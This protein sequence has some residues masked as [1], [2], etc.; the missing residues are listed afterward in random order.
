MVDG[1]ETDDG[2]TR[3]TYLQYGA[4]LSAGLLAG[5]I[6][7][8]GDGSTDPATETATQTPTATATET[9]TP[10]DGSYSVTMAPMGETTF[11]SVP[12]SY[13]AEGPMYADMAIAAG[14]GDRLEAMLFPTDWVPLPAVYYEQFDVPWTRNDDIG[15][16]WAD[17]VPSKER[18]Y[19]LDPDVIH[20]D[21]VKTANFSGFSEADVAEIEENVAPFFGNALRT[22]LGRGAE[23][24]D[25]ESYDI[26][27]AFEKI[28]AVYQREDRVA[29]F[30]RLH[31]DLRT[32]VQERVPDDESERPEIAV[33]AV[34]GNDISRGFG[35]QRLGEQNLERQAYRLLGARDA[36]DD[37]G[38]QSVGVGPDSNWQFGY[39]QLLEMDPDV[40]VFDGFLAS[41]GP[42]AFREQFV[43]PLRDHPV[44]SQ[45]AAVQNDRLYRGG[46]QY[47]GPISHLVNIEVAAKQLYPD[48]FGSFTTFGDMSSSERLFDRG[49]VNDIVAGR[50]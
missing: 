34:L 12:E 21:P 19:A 7:T 43:E 49:R 35:A 33:V 23:W 14:V 8:G 46:A 25:Y 6:G 40:I 29:P 28:A 16:Y 17:G 22:G 38:L 31:E 5:C 11:E 24:Y 3:R 2:S 44:G 1:D 13:I 30:R 20:A 26:L 41:F 15:S 4:V 48:V 10:D 36:F 50:V 39:E 37:T 27:D 47:Q 9:T 42:E 18:L 45:L 32:R